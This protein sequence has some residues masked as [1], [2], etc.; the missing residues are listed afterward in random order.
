M[1]TTNR[2]KKSIARLLALVMVLTMMPMNVIMPQ[3]GLV[4]AEAVDETASTPLRGYVRSKTDGLTLWG[5]NATVNYGTILLAIG[6]DNG[7]KTTVVF[8]TE[9]GESEIAQVRIKWVELL[10]E[11]EAGIARGKFADGAV[12]A[13]PGFRPAD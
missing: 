11:G 5:K 2:W 3:A 10:S 8:R 6:Q 1:K 9:G 13:R 7:D 12:N 4:M